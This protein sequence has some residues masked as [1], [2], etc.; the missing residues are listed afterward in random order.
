MTYILMAPEGF[1]LGAQIA[2]PAGAVF[3]AVLFA[4]YIAAMGKA[5]KAGALAPNDR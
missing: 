5:K 2:Y 3:A 1:R 4:I